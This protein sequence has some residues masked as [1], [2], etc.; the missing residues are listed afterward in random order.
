[1]CQ[2]DTGAARAET[3]PRPR[4]RPRARWLLIAGAV[5]LTL[6]LGASGAV[7]TNTNYRVVGYAPEFAL[8]F[9]AWQTIP[10]VIAVFRPLTAWLIY[11]P[12]LL[13][14]LVVRPIHPSE[15]WPLLPTALIAYLVVQFALARSRR[16][17]V[18]VPCWFVMV[19]GYMLVADTGEPRWDTGPDFTLFALLSALALAVGAGLRVW[20]Q[21]RARLAAEERLTAEERSRRELLEERAR[22]AREM[23]DIV[24][25]HMS[26]IAVQASTAAYRLPDLPPA[27]V[28]EFA[29]IGGAARESLTEMR[30]LLKVLRNEVDDAPRAPQPGLERLASLVDGTVRAGTPVTL[31]TVDLPDEVP[32]L[33]GLTAFRVVQ[34]ALSNVVRHA[35]GAQTRVEVRA[36]R[37]DLRIVV[38]N[39]QAPGFRAPLE[40]TG[41]GHGLAGMRERAAIVGGEVSAGPRADGGFTVKARLPLRADGPVEAGASAGP[42]GAAAEAEEEEGS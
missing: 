34:E 32:E 18:V 25:H 39:D 12:S 3:R 6:I 28:E 19:V 21:A 38:D 15:P 31:S 35:S 4:A 11:A 9:S 27:A 16:L 17:L 2:Q 37:T 7:F 30:R 23:H 40:P 5:A 13:V 8:W 29:A 33:V 20:S 36:D 41:P 1:M 26:M 10:L 42:A 22:I 14:P 24:A